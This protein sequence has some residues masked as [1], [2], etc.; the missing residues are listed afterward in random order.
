MT[1]ATSNKKKS[2]GSGALII[3]IVVVIAGV[4]CFCGALG[5]GA[6]C[7]F[8]FVKKKRMPGITQAEASEAPPA[9]EA[10]YEMAPRKF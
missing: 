10:A 6:I 8:M 5:I 2:G 9:P 1:P 3:I 7:G 4:I